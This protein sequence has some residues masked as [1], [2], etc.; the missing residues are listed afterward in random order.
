GL[1]YLD[2]EGS[3]V[4]ST[5]NIVD[6][7]DLYYYTSLNTGGSD[8]TVY[9][10]GT[11]GD[12]YLYNS[13]GSDTVVIG[14]SAQSPP[15]T[16]SLAAIKRLLDGYGYGP[17]HLDCERGGRP[18]RPG[19]PP[20]Q[21]SLTGLSPAEIWYGTNVSSLT[22]NAGTGDDKLTVAGTSPYTQTAFNG[23]GGTDTLV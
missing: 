8:D 6:T 12:L 14:R 22:I 15:G 4:G 13:F 21:H 5:Y 20:T 17:T 9:I 1:T 7:P 19:A 23:G 2:I 11:T 16:G 10:T 18:N 3:A